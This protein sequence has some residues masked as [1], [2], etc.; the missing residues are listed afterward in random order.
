MNEDWSERVRAAAADSQPSGALLFAK[1]ILRDG[2]S[3]DR[4]GPSND[5]AAAQEHLAFLTAISPDHA[6]ELR[7]LAEADLAGQRQQGH[8]EFVAK[9]LNVGEA[10]WDAAKHP[11]GGNSENSG[12][13]STTWGSKAKAVAHADDPN[14]E[15]YGN[16]V[17]GPIANGPVGDTG[18][19]PGRA[20]F[21][22]GP[23]PGVLVDGTNRDQFLSKAKADLDAAFHSG[24][25][26]EAEENIRLEVVRAVLSGK[27]LS[28]ADAAGSRDKE[29]WAA[30]PKTGEWKF[31]DA[32]SPVGVMDAA[33]KANG[34]DRIGFWCK[35]AAQFNVLRGQAEAAD[36][37][38]K[39][40]IDVAARGKVPSSLFP[41]YDMK[42]DGVYK[43]KFAD[44]EINN[45]AGID[46]KTLLPG[47]QTWVQNPK[48]SGTEAGS[49]KFYIGDGKFADPYSLSPKDSARIGRPPDSVPVKDYNKYL[50]F[51]HNEAGKP[52]IRTLKI[53]RVARPIVPRY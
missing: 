30:D 27:L 12:Q 52:D 8:M 43:G 40:G 39:I 53:N 33:Y 13:F 34:N 31:E 1:A 21:I 29:L 20:Q 6:T 44:V 2:I 26:S 16:S 46:P 51:V 14:G 25:I 37:A 50:D 36:N 32:A 15:K 23:D 42:K 10:E 41:E 11:R 19:N 49:N 47:D 5:R 4:I 38:G 17:Q 7:R 48:G 3:S 24:R 9:I 18:S 22:A 28:E 45:S 35:K